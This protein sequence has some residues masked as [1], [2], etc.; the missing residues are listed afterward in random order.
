[1]ETDHRVPSR[2]VAANRRAAALTRRLRRSARR[3]RF[4][5]KLPCVQHRKRRLKSGEKVPMKPLKSASRV[6]LQL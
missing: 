6:L 5:P 1:M 4:S 3:G 2:V